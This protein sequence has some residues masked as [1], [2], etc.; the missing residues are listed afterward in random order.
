MTEF[1]VKHFVKDYEKTEKVSVRTG[2]GILASMVGIFC[3]V[4]LFLMKITIGMMIHSISVIADAFNN[5]SDAGSSIISF[6]GVKIASKPAD[7]E[8]P[9]GH[10][11]MEYIAALVVAFLVLQVG[12]T[13]FKDAVGDKTSTGDRI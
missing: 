11:R 3:N 5:L 2:Y 7:K 13:F 4:L 12:F 10:G 6:I 1:L 8:H 9:F